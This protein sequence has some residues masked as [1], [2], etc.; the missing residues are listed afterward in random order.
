MAMMTGFCHIE[1]EGGAEVNP[2]QYDL[3]MAS[4]K[5]LRVVETVLDCCDMDDIF[6]FTDMLD[7]L[8]DGKERMRPILDLFESQGIE[9]LLDANLG[10][11]SLPLTSCRWLP[12]HCFRLKDSRAGPLKFKG[13]EKDPIVHHWCWNSFVMWGKEESAEM[14]LNLSRLRL[15]D[16][17]E[18]KKR[19]NL[20]DTSE[21]TIGPDQEWDY[22]QFLELFLG[23]E[24]QV[25]QLI[26]SKS[27][28]CQELCHSVC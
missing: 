9:F 22:S 8:A 5:V 23:R 24:G 21:V 28:P 16:G 13:F 17:E 3:K 15:T 25:K 11:Q 26:C 19:I 6:N 12:P 20:K 18:L 1:H 2:S 27:V 10:M 7:V 4:L 14:E